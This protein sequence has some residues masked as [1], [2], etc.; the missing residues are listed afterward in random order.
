LTNTGL[1][2]MQKPPFIKIIRNELPDVRQHPVLRFEHAFLMRGHMLKQ[3]V[4]QPVADQTR[5]MFVFKLV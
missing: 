4:D 2:V 3:P 1:A 5:L